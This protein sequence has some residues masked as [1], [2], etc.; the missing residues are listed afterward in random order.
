MSGQNFIL[1]GG[2]GFIGRHVAEKLLR[3]GHHVGIAARDPP[4]QYGTFE[5]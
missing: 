2:N 1:V 3:L 4:P 5:A